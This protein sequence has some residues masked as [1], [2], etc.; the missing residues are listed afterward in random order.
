MA[1]EDTWTSH[2]NDYLHRCTT[3]TKQSLNYTV[4]VYCLDNLKN[5]ILVN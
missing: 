2:F 3:F 1:E 5:Q 4:N